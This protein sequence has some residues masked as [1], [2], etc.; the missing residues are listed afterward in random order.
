MSTAYD[1]V[2]YP[3]VIHH[4]LHP[5][6]MAIAA[7]LAGLSP[8]PMAEARVLDIGGGTC[9]TLTAFAAQYPTAQAH[10]FDLAASAIA[11]G[12]ELAGPECANVHLVVEDIVAARQRYAAGSFDYVI[13]HGIYAWVPE[14]VREALL[15][16]IDH[17]L[18]DRGVALV[19]YNA[20]PGGYVRLMMRDMLLYAVDGITDPDERVA[21]AYAFLRSYAEDETK[22]D[23]PLLTGLRKHAESMAARS[24]A[25][26]FHDELGDTYAPQAISQ[27]VADAGRHCLKF[28]TDAGRNRGFDGFLTM[29]DRDTAEADA[30]SHVLRAAQSR[31]YL[32]LCFFRA[33]LLVRDTAPVCRRIDR[34]AIDRL[35]A[36]AQLKP[37]GDG[38]FEHGEDRFA[39]SD[40]E[41]ASAL[42]SLAAAWPARRPVAELLTNDEQRD[43]MLE[44]YR[45]WYVT[46]H[47][48][49]PPFVLE[50]GDRPTT[51]PWIRGMLA[52]GEVEIVSLALRMMRIDQPDLRALLMTAD[53]TRTLEELVSGDHGMAGDQVPGA[54]AAA[55]ARALLV[56]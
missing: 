14:P 23:D 39:I 46:L 21:T 1:R 31:D 45:R 40:P 32:Q 41:L 28:L 56:A 11:R 10:G 34:A 26:V 19:S 12:Q 5:E 48:D 33:T 17:V 13:A 25:V 47:L 44:L 4:P 7:H 15:A 18:S 36:S 35:W 16:L 2:A 51:A 27:F 24:P 8:V 6:R 50:P 53:G 38:E 42:E 37:L 55:A 54:L 20:M 3:T 43:A 9:L 52:R 29:D 49:R 22:P 30:D